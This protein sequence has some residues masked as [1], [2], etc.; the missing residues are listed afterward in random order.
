MAKEGHG[1]NL[2]TAFLDRWDT[3]LLKHSPVSQASKRASDEH[4]DFIFQ[5]GEWTVSGSASFASGIR[6]SAVV[7][8]L[9][10]EVSGAVVHTSLHPLPCR[11]TPIIILTVGFLGGRDGKHLKHTSQRALIWH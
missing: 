2:Q 6:L 5:V 3:L 1:C 9:R 4:C 7:L 10:Q 11:T 8:I